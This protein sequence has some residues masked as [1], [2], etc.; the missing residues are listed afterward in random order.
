MEYT[1][2]L[3]YGAVMSKVQR[4]RCRPGSGRVV[5]VY[6]IDICKPGN[7]N[8]YSTQSSSKE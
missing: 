6:S 2:R 7:Q 1:D 3:V 8:S 5:I 4:T